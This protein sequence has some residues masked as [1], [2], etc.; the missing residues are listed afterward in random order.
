MSDL[1]EPQLDPQPDP[2]PAEPQRTETVPGV[3]QT[4]HATPPAA[5]KPAK[6]SATRF[7]FWGLLGGCLLFFVGMTALVALAAFSANRNN[8]VDWQFSPGARIA[9]VPI[10][11]EILEARDVIDAIHRYRENDA[12]KAMVIR[13]NSPGGAVAPSQEIYEEIRKV[14]RESGKPFVASIDIVGASG[15]FYIASAC[16]RI[17]AN[18]GSITGSIGVIMQWMNLED[19][20]RWAKLKPETITAGGMKDIGSPYR[21]MKPEERVYLARIAEQL[22]QQFIRAVAEGRSGKM[23]VAEVTTIADGRVFTGEEALSLKLIDQLGNLDD[24]VTLASKLAGMR[25]VPKTI[26]PRKRSPGL[27]NLLT[28]S[29]DSETMLQR[30]LTSRAG[31]FL[32]RW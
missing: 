29:E 23:T 1:N 4:A 19:L 25:R 13:I 17:V 16:D 21:E 3:R 9:V 10:E 8:A 24:S 28:H 14:R 18:P 31:R 26:Y 7:F 27:L 2:A 30:I 12:V 6:G 20:V 5:A 15:G 22:H 32:Y 11:G